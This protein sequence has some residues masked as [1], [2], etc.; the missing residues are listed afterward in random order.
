MAHP[1]SCLYQ[2]ENLAIM[3]IL[4]KTL[5]KDKNLNLNGNKHAEN[6]SNAGSTQLKTG[7]LMTVQSYDRPSKATYQL[8]L[9]F[10]WP[11]PHRHVTYL[12]HSATVSQLR[13]FSALCDYVLPESGP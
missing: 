6:N 12:G 5:G 13:P 9:M 3:D 7:C 1:L 8:V 11:F 2:I 10:L 4:N